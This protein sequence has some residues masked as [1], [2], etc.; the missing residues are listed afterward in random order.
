MRLL[1][2]THSFLWFIGGDTSLSA[3][4]RS[5]I[6]DDRNEVFLSIASLWEI[7]IKVSLGKLRLEQPF[8]L[9][10]P[11]TTLREQYPTVCY[12]D[13]SYLGSRNPSVSSP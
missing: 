3:R 8:D 6:E 7:A 4:A 13:S 9:L 5:L 12:H 10:I 2:D 11:P 1:L